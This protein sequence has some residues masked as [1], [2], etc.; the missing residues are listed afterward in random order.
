MADL[1]M[2]KDGVASRTP[3]PQSIFGLPD[4]YYADLSWLDVVSFGLEGV[5]WFPAVDQSPPLGRF[6]EYGDQETLTPDFDN[7]V[8]RV[9]RNIVKQ[10]NLSRRISPFGF[11]NRFTL[12]EKVAVEMAAL[13]DATA[14]QDARNAA[15][16]VRAF[17]RDMSVAKY[18][19][20][21]GVATVAGLQFMESLGIL[22][23]DRVTEIA[24]AE[25]TVE[26]EA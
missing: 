19:D 23:A 4:E 12:D 17:L 22:T 15:A 10:V 3:V 14:S 8:V 16:M 24:T 5:V 6:E 7:K 25:V 2:V 13:D 18:V 20:L 9:V 1:I 11:R 26:E 21:D